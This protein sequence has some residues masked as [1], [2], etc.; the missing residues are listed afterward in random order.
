MFIYGT[1]LRLWGQHRPR[2]PLGMENPL[3]ARKILHSAF[4]AAAEGTGI[5]EVPQCSPGALEKVQ[6]KPPSTTEQLR[7]FLGFPPASGIW[8]PQNQ[9]PHTPLPF[10]LAQL[11]L[12]QH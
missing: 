12:Q 6:P 9:P 3:W 8:L 2:D 5:A 11:H 4:P 7:V 10:C 1:A